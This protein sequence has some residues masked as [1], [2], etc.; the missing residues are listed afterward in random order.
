LF[1]DITPCIPLKVTG[2]F[3]GMYR[4]HL[5]GEKIQQ[6]R[7]EYALPYQQVIKQ[8]L[9][10]MLALVFSLGLFFDPEDG[11]DVFLHDIRYISMDY[12][13]LYPTR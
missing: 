10:C 4:L 9:C 1:W 2:H 13:V 8:R 3:G 12:I 7:N 11:G 6:C 5:Q